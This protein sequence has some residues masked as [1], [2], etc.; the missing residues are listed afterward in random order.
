MGSRVLILLKNK[1]TIFSLFNFIV[2]KYCS[3]VKEVFAN[4]LEQACCS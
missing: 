1:N 4:V 2:P 3:T